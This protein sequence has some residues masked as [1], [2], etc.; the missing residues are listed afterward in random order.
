[1]QTSHL[2]IPRPHLVPQIAHSIC[3]RELS[4][5]KRKDVDIDKKKTGIVARFKQMFKD[6]WYILV[7]VH[8]ATSIVWFGCFYFMC[9]SGV[10]VVAILGRS[11]FYLALSMSST[12]NSSKKH[13][14][15]NN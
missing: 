15:S 12:S 4:S 7:P 6:Y 1:M 3:Y 14:F 2:H 5:G 8:V 9:K 13:R 10:D 11:K